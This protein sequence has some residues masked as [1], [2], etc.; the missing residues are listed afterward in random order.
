MLFPLF[1]ANIQTL[2]W[3]IL[4]LGLSKNEGQ[5]HIYIYIYIYIYVTYMSTTALIKSIAF[6]HM[7]LLMKARD[8][9]V[10]AAS[11]ERE[12]TPGIGSPFSAVELS[13]LVPRAILTIEAFMKH[14]YLT[15]EDRFVEL[16]LN[17]VLQVYF[18]HVDAADLNK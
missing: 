6:A 9:I 4:G 13:D 1:F 8:S 18:E 16:A 14:G 12:R 11:R 3:R 17:D 2:G 15:S 10:Q 7:M 5:Q